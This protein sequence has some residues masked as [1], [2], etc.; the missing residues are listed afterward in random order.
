LDRDGISLDKSSWKEKRFSFEPDAP[1][2]GN[3][4]CVRD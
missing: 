4:S 1:D 3:V 2:K